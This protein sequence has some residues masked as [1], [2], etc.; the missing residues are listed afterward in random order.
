MKSDPKSIEPTVQEVNQGKRYSSVSKKYVRRYDPVDTRSRILESAYMFFS[1]VGYD[2]CSTADIAREAGVS[3]G[4]IFYHFT[5]KHALLAELGKTHG[6]RLVSIMEGDAKVPADF[7]ASIERCFDYFERIVLEERP[8]ATGP[9]DRLHARPR[10]VYPFFDAA[11]A[12]VADWMRQKIRDNSMSPLKFDENIAASMM[13]ALLD[14]AVR[15]YLAPQTTPAMRKI[16]RREWR[17][18]TRALL[19]PTMIN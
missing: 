12:I 1:T 9:D 8:D 17:R 15:Q 18:F 16:I 7:V 10:E 3:E 14:D 13:T 11:R 19:E 4:S 2:S 6:Q 5:S